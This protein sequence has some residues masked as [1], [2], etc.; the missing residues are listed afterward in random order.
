MPTTKRKRVKSSVSYVLAVSL[1]LLLGSCRQNLSKKEYV[2]YV[3]SAALTHKEVMMGELVYKLTYLPTDFMALLESKG[4]TKEMDKGQFARYMADF[5]NGHYFKLEIGLT[6]GE[7]VLAY[8]LQSEDELNH[9]IYYFNQLLQEEVYLETPE[10][11]LI[12]PVLSLYQN[13][14]GLKP[15]V[16]VLLAFPRR[17]G[18]QEVGFKYKN[19]L[20]APS[21]EVKL[22]FNLQEIENKMPTL[23][24]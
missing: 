20:F 8:G 22:P 6:T 14:H 21:S 23:N 17:E 4:A 3:Q 1:L 7:S 18:L 2:Q 9:R 10:G 5:E 16:S 12:R 13:T 15:T 19:K 24:L 11:E